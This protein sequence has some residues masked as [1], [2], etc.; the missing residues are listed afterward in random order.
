MDSLTIT[1]KSGEGVQKDK[2]GN[3]QEAMANG[4]K[5]EII[6]E[7]KVTGLASCMKDHIP[8]LAIT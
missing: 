6:K 7:W 5:I 8:R 2:K 4:K 1:E 3:R